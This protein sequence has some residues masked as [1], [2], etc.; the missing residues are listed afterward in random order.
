[1]ATK[2]DISS[3]IVDPDKDQTL[4]WPC[5]LQV[6]LLL[7]LFA[8]YMYRHPRAQKCQN[9]PQEEMHSFKPEYRPKVNINIILS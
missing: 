7:K 9:H 2:R 3:S 8:I 1:M 5:S 4:T 6:P